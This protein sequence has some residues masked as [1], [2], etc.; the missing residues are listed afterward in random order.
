MLYSTALLYLSASTYSL[1]CATLLVFNA[2]FSFFIN[3]KKFTLSIFNS[4]I[5]LT[6]AAVLL[7]INEDSDKPLGITRWKYIIGIIAATVASA[8]YSLILPLMEFSFQKVIKK[9]TFSVVLEMQIYTSLVATGISTIGL[10]ASGEWRSLSGEMHAFTTGK[11]AYVQVLVWTALGWQIAAV[12]VVGLIFVASSSLFSNVISTFSLAVTPIAS[13]IILHD[14]MNVVK[15]IALLMVMWGFGSYIYQKY[16]DD[17]KFPAL[18]SA[19]YKLVILGDES[20][21]KSSII[22]R[23]MIDKFYNK[24]EATIG[25]DFL[26]KKV[27]LEDHE[28]RLQIWDTAG[29]ERFKSL[30]PSYI[31]DSDCSV[32]VYDVANRQSFLNTSKW[33]EKVRDDLGRDAIIILVGNKTDLVEKRQ[34]SK[35]EGE[36][37]ARELDV[38]FFETSAKSGWNI[39]PL[40]RK[41]GEGLSGWSHYRRELYYMYSKILRPNFYSKMQRIKNMIFSLCESKKRMY[42]PIICENES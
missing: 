13:V 22:T 42:A 3:S 24:Y 27:Y 19:R 16:L 2:I 17:T 36:A 4:V 25:I 26:S 38:I 1:I 23:F 34:V 28:V 8:L 31:R 40:F 11:A 20:V 7:A 10:F 5:A 41:I 6:S 30:I 29:I 35:E 21:G 39:K 14:K 37:K 9:E 32:I 15:V 18:T 33:I 12:G